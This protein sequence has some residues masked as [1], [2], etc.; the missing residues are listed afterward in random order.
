MAYLEIK[1]IDGR[2]YCYIMQSVRRGGKAKRR[3][4]EHLG[5]DPDS[6]RLK[7]TLRYWKVTKGRK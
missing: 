6:K 5:R 7:A 2:A 4:L 1:R 3:I